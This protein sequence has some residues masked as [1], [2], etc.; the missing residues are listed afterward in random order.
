MYPKQ[1]KSPE[2]HALKSTALNLMILMNAKMTDASPKG[3]ITTDA[4]VEA[5]KG[6]VEPESW[7]LGRGK[8]NVDV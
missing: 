3:Y 4:Y 7:C 2:L 8:S 6:I 5:W 1:D